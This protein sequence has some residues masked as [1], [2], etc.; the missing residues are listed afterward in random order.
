MI[1]VADAGGTKTDWWVR[2][3]SS[4]KEMNFSTGGLNPSVMSP[5]SI[6]ERIKFLQVQIKGGAIEADYEGEHCLFLFAAGCNSPETKDLLRRCFVSALPIELNRVYISSDLEGAARAVLG[7]ENGIACILGTGSASALYDG[8]E[9]VD[10]VP[11]L[12]YILGDEGSGAF[13]GKNLI[14]RYFKRELGRTIAEKLEDWTDM[15]MYQ[16][17]NKVYK[18]G[19]TN[20]FLAS[21]VPFLKENEKIEE[22]SLLIDSSLKLFFEKNVLKYK[23]KKSINKIGFVGGVA[24]TFEDRLIRLADQY[25]LESIGVIDRPIDY[26]SRYYKTNEY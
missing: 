3:T 19:E 26:L 23:N 20:K 14:N 17:L 4:G 16:V 6:E 9:I 22:I 15:S 10:S 21:F 13:M 18:E 1:I 7:N 8:K 2:M 11:S 12:G 25:G 24:K 5:S